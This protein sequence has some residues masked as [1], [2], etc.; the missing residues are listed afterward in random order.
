MEH[1]TKG[2]IKRIL[3]TGVVVFLGTIES[4][5]EKELDEETKRRN[6]EVISVY[7]PQKVNKNVMVEDIIDIQTK[8]APRDFINRKKVKEL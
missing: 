2:V 6:G 1:A 7:L 4:R 8:I 5:D 3:P